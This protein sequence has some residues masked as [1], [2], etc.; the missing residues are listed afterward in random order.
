M[1]ARRLR[2]GG[3]EGAGTGAIP[4]LGFRGTAESFS[5]EAG[6]AGVAA[7]PGTLVGESTDWDGSRRG[8]AASSFAGSSTRTDWYVKIPMKGSNSTPLVALVN[9]VE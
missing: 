7:A 1:A 4:G 6:T 8:D 9:A 2:C 3:E 5:E